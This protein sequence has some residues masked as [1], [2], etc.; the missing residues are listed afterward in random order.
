MSEKKRILHVEDHRSLQEL[1]R[2]AL[3]RLGD[4]AV[5]TAPDGFRAIE[6]AVG[7]DPD[8]I[9]LDLDL[10]RRDG[11]ETLAVL[12][13]TEGLRD[14]PVMFLTAAVDPE[15]TA[16]L[17]SLGACEVLAKPIRPRALVSAVDRA[18]APE[19]H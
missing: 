7:F 15:V 17:R 9:L 4:Y 10:P 14:V 11:V 5:C 1:V 13:D 12:R 3:E 16:R 6:L 2:I 19:A 18:L 8:L